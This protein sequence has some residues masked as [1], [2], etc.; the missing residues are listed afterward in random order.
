MAAVSAFAGTLSSFP[1]LF[2]G[3]TM[4]VFGLFLYIVLPFAVFLTLMRVGRNRE[5]VHW[6]SLAVFGLVAALCASWFVAAW[7]YGEKYQ[8]Y[9]A[10]Y[11]LAALNAATAILV[12]L[13]FIANRRRPTFRTRVIFNWLLVVWLFGWAFPYLGEYP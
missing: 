10:T 9:G 4:S 13:P 6:A 11:F 7:S 2:A 3:V 8:G 1:F 5:R 12:I